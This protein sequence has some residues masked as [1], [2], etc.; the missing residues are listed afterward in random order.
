MRILIAAVF[1]VLLLFPTS[2]LAFIFG[3]ASFIAVGLW[4]VWLP[5]GVI[6]WAKAAHRCLQ[7]E[8]DESLFPT[9]RFIGTVFIIMGFLILLAMLFHR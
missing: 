7:E 9:V 1:F 4:A 2:Y 5:S 3:I 6:G 8:D